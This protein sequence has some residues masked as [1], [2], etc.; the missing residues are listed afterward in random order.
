MNKREIS[1]KRVGPLRIFL[2]S[3]AGAVA[4][5]AIFLLTAFVE[6]FWAQRTVVLRGAL[7]TTMVALFLTVPIVWPIVLVSGSALLITVRNRAI[8]FTWFV[9]AGLM[10][11]A[12][13]VTFLWNWFWGTGTG[14]DAVL[15]ILGGAAGATAGG[16][17][18]W[19]VRTS[20]AGEKQPEVV[21]QGEPVRD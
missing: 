2:G 18:A 14:F 1:L 17:F 4:A 8:P 15:I 19:V 10:E 20:I 5:I 3:L 21:G 16:V 7:D 9:L 13:V 11:G 6:G 12:A